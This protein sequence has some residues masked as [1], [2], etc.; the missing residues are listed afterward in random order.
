MFIGSKSLY[1][2][3]QNTPVIQNVKLL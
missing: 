1:I 2:T 3:L